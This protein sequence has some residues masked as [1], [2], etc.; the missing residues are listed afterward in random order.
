MSQ[1]VGGEL[2]LIERDPDEAFRL[3]E[4]YKGQV[5]NEYIRTIDYLGTNSCVFMQG[6]RVYNYL[7][8]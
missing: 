8:I 4:Q 1:T 7:S 6:E 2:Q 3:I 5:P